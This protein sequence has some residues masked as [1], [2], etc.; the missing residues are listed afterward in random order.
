MENTTN[1][2]KQIARVFDNDL[3]TKQWQNWGDYIIIWFFIS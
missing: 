3:R 2:K 1:I